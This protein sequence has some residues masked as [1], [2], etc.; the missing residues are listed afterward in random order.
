MNDSDH[1]DRADHQDRPDAPQ[2]DLV[3]P[4]A[5]APPVTSFTDLDLPPR[6]SARSARSA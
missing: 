3:G 4:E 2:G 1:Q 6:C 5:A